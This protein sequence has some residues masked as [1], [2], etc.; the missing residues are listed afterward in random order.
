MKDINFAEIFDQEGRV[1]TILGKSGSGKTTLL[2]YIL[3]KTN[4]C[5]RYVF[6]LQGSRPYKDN[7][8]TDYIWPENIHYIDVTTMDKKLTT[9]VSD[10]KKYSDNIIQKNLDIDDQKKNNPNI[11]LEPIKTLFI[12]DDLSEYTKVFSSLCNVMRHSNISFIFLCHN[13]TN[14]DKTFRTKIS[15]FLV[16]VAFDLG[17]IGEEQFQKNGD[18]NK[19]FKAL[20]N[21]F[22]THEKNKVFLLID[23]LKPT[24]NKKY[25]DL[26]LD[27]IKEIEESYPLF[28]NGSKQ[29]KQ[30]KNVLTN[31]A[32]EIKKENVNTNLTKNQ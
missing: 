1:L 30:I 28:Y 19:E 15:H 3:S 21:S 9:M 16:N 6:L 2:K 10:I 8:Y 25:I 5:F 31:L 11:Y 4:K 27:D 20:Q 18:K 24:N 22:L 14:M 13:V 29:R 7:I 23:T 12:F 17:Q 32:L 26:T